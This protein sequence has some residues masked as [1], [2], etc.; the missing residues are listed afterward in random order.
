M[1]YE[2]ITGQRYLVDRLMIGILCDG[3]V[4]IEGVPGLV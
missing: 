3:H 1:L 2:V 4:L